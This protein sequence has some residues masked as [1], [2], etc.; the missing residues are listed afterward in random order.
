M[1][2]QA[3]ASFKILETKSGFHFTKV[4][5]SHEK[6]LCLSAGLVQARREFFFP[7]LY[8]VK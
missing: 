7:N 6:G 3:K 1:V 5:G 8:L 2:A 4:Y